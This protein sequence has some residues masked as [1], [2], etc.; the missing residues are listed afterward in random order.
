MSSSDWVIAI[1]MAL[2][3][4]VSA[5]MS[6]KLWRGEVR[7]YRDPLMLLGPRA[8][9]AFSRALP[10]VA[11]A[12]PIAALLVL[13]ALIAPGH[14]DP[15]WTRVLVFV[16]G[17]LLGTAVL[18]ALCVALLG[19][20][21]FLAAPELPAE[22]RWDY[23]AA[24][25]PEA[26]RAPSERVST[27]RDSRQAALQAAF[28]G[29][30]AAL[31]FAGAVTVIENA[32]VGVTLGTLFA[33]AMLLGVYRVLVTGVIADD[34]GIVVV[35][36]SRAVSVAWHQIER[37]ELVSGDAHGRLARVRLRRGGTLRLVGLESP[38]LRMRSHD[39]WAEHAVAE[40][41]ARLR[42]GRDAM[43]KLEPR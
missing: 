21:S 36:G 38:Q 37:F 11:L 23:E 12:V 22:P 3:L 18:A 14:D 33:G 30:A 13:P 4:P 7:L 6:V 16:A 41:N 29:V 31:G 17:A 27:Y 20:P 10:L 19:R 2:V 43:S 24:E 26:A 5:F 1:T 34:E 39:A 32:P 15:A 25:A 28:F 35:N 8:W 9:R 42:E 40:L